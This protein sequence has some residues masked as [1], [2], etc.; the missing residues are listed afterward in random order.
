VHSSKRRHEAQLLYRNG[1]SELEREQLDLLGL[2]PIKGAASGRIELT[3][4]GG[5]A[6]AVS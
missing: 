5:Q 1:P 3:S 2:G 6:R 4:A